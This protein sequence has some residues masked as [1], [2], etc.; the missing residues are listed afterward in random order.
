[1]KSHSIALLFV[2]ALSTVPVSKLQ[3]ADPDSL[4]FSSPVIQAFMAEANQSGKP[5][6]VFATTE[7]CVRTHALKKGLESTPEI[8][9][10][11][12]QYEKREI[13][14]GAQDFV[15]LFN[16]AVKRDP[17]LPRAIGS[18]SAFLFTSDGKM[19]YAG[20]NNENGVNVESGM[21]L[22]V[23]IDGVYKNGGIIP[24]QDPGKIA[25]AASSLDAAKKLFAAGKIKQAVELVAEMLAPQQNGQDEQTMKLV[26]MT[27][28]PI[29]PAKPDK[30][31]TLFI[32]QMAKQADD[33]IRDCLRLADAKKIGLA[34][35]KLIEAHLNYLAIES[36]HSEF[37]AA[38]DK[39]DAKAKDP[40]FKTVAA[41]VFE[42][43]QM[44]KMEEED[45]QKA[46]EVYRDVLK[47]HPQSAFCEYCRT[48]LREFEPPAPQVVR[49][50]K[51]AK[52][53]YQVRAT[54]VSVEDGKASLKTEE[55]KSIDVK[56]DVLSAE[57]QAYLEEYRKGQKSTQP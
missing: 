16:D 36:I 12:S 17:S 53:T 57:D 47:N 48:R 21:L 27:G 2:F 31:L 5:L 14:F 7:T 23:L 13:K 34:A 41:A 19:V 32:E 25:T 37:R 42:A 8:A 38:W 44:E 29:A 55:G 50:W 49:T 11:L 28:L 45:K 35:I 30:S 39:L 3:C 4:K 26:G 52:G 22:Q 15:M 33:S 24:P 54:L 18:P 46:I 40:N 6:L 43:I 56:V 20:P 10:L 1:M 51:S 9:A